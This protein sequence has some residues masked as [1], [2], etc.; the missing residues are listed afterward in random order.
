MLTY[1]V[2]SAIPF[3]DTPKMSE[4]VSIT[5]IQSITESAIPHNGM[6]IFVLI[7]V[8]TKNI[9]GLALWIAILCSLF[10]NKRENLQ[11]PTMLLIVSFGFADLLL[12]GVSTIEWS[13]ANSYLFIQIR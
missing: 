9:I 4:L 12:L 11:D 10:R 3:V 2:Q 1:G 13:T 6:S 8:F 7:L 5:P